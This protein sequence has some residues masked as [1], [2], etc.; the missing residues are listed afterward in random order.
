MNPHAARLTLLASLLV[1]AL[2]AS[3]YGQTREDRTIGD[4]ITVFDEIMAIPANS[5]PEAMLNDA[6][7]VAIIPS[8]IKGSFIVGA[9]HGNGVILVRDENNRWYAPMFISLTG[10]NIGWQVG[11]QSTDV[12]LV[13]KTRQSVEGLLSGKL[14]LGADAAAAAG[15]VGRQAAVAT[16]GRLNAE[17][18]SYSRSRGLFAGVS[19]DGSVIKVDPIANAT[20]YRA[21]APNSPAVVPDIANQ[22][23]ARVERAAGTTASNASDSGNSATEPTETT[24]NGASSAL[25]Q[26]HSIDEAAHLRDQLAKLAPELFEVLD[27]TWQN[28]LALPAEV[29]NGQSHPSAETLNASL[30]RY[31][32]VR[33]DAKYNALSSRAEFQSTYGLLVHYAE[34]LAGNRQPISLP[35]PPGTRE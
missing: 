7:G 25:A 5:I 33:S 2:T 20:Y 35:A 6:Y 29:F 22:L 31:N 18:Y 23:V 17:I 3:A 4:A 24:Q 9:R 30:S 15:P 12:I 10:G 1:V 11:V 13:F 28:Y 26:Q 32:A 14:T 8:V 21:V 27:P 19:F 16:D 34:A